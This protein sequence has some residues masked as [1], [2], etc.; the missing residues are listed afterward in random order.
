[1]LAI[2]LF[3]NTYLNDNP[4]YAITYYPI[5]LTHNST[6]LIDPFPALGTNLGISEALY[7]SS[8]T[9]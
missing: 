4:G 1:M 7:A 3:N 9:F 8:G 6:S 5:L 2:V